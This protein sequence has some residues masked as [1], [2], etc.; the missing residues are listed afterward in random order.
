MDG[1]RRLAG[2]RLGALGTLV[3][4]ALG[5]CATPP[6]DPAARAQFERTNDPLEPMNRRIFAFNLAVDDAVG[7][8]VA[9]AYRDNVPPF[10]KTTLRNLID[11]WNSPVVFINDVLQG[12]HVRAAE[13]ATRFW[14][15][16]L[17]GFAGF[18]DVAGGYGL[19]K[20]KE[21]FGQTLAVWGV[22]EGPYLMVPLL[23]PSNP[24][25]LAGRVVDS[26]INPLSYGLEAAGVGW[27]EIIGAGVDAIDT[28]A[29]LLDTTE[30]L[31]RTSLDYYSSVRSLYRQDREGE[32]ANG[33]LRRVPLPGEEDE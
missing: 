7:K 31:R 8:P 29:R 13:T 10:V 4:V 16:S 19:V 32:I 6:T 24:R 18:F 26:F 20:H 30:E 28:R 22:S 5:A 15:N 11:N 25:D 9:I 14:V 33:R 12:E 23:G 27:L 21:D 2:A 1:I 17:F 3:I